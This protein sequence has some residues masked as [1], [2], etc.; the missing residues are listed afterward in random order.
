MGNV[1]AVHHVLAPGTAGPGSSG[2]PTPG[3]GRPSVFRRS[4]RGSNLPYTPKPQRSVWVE[5]R[6]PEAPAQG[7]CVWCN[8]EFKDKRRRRWCGQ[9][10]VREFNRLRGVGVRSAAMRANRRANHGALVCVNCLLLLLGGSSKDE[11]RARLPPRPGLKDGSYDWAANQAY[12]D[13][14]LGPRQ[15]EV[16]HIL[17]LALGG[18]LHD[19]KN[20]QVLCP[21][22]HREKTRED[23]GAIA[24]AR[25]LARMTEGTSQLEEFA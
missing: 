14:H 20:L 6:F 2:Q 5:L 11:A 8:G 21:K 23:I 25:R 3:V 13:E 7:R 16:D 12:Y 17:P 1:A 15:P 4:R 19:L 24:K 22:C 9:K 10:C 18:S